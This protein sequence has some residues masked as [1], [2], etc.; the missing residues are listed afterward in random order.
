MKLVYGDVQ[1]APADW[2]AFHYGT[3]DYAMG[4][5]V[6]MYDDKFVET[7]QNISMGLL[8]LQHF[9]LGLAWAVAATR[10]GIDAPYAQ[11]LAAVACHNLDRHEA[12][13]AFLRQVRDSAALCCF[14]L[15]GAWHF[16]HDLRPG[17]WCMLPHKASFGPLMPARCQRHLS[18][19]AAP[20]PRC[21]GI[22]FMAIESGG[23]LIHLALAL[24]H[25]LW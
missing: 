18:A 19:S 10:L 2:A 8:H 12:A 20:A 1:S 13:L 25:K 4:A 11:Y 5:I 22:S 3:A 16:V 14:L 23:L 17:L 7:L 15:L 6:E 9:E 21:S 24:P